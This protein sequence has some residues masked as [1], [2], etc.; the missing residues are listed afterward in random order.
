LSDIFIESLDY[1][2]YAHKI[3][4]KVYRGWVGVKTDK[5]GLL[6]FELSFWKMKRMRNVSC[7]DIKAKTK[8]KSCNDLVKPK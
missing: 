5:K 1:S 7:E 4:F 3:C 2:F 8:V 6:G